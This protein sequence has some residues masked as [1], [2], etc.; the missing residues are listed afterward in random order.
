MNYTLYFALLG[1]LWLAIW[2]SVGWYL[3]TRR[4]K[5]PLLRRLS[6]K[7][8]GLLIVA[9]VAIPFLYCFSYAPFKRSGL[10]DLYVPVQWLFD[11]TALRT[12]LLKNAE[13]WHASPNQF[14]ADSESRLRGNFWGTLP[15]YTY[16]TGWILMGLAW[17]LLPPYLMYRLS[18][19]YRTKWHPDWL[20]GHPA[21]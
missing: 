9:V 5:G 19:W 17:C 21:T 15:P 14:L 18:L 4:T 1:V 16:A 3:E 11:H 20:K 7:R 13:L 12:P 6:A 10:D 8:R 2:A